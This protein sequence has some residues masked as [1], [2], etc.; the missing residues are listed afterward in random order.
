VRRAIDDPHVEI[1]NVPPGPREPSPI[2]SVDTESFRLLERTMRQVVP[3]AL[4]VPWLVVGGTDS[5]NFTSISA[6]VYRIGAMRLG[7]DD[8]KRAHGTDERVS[9]EAYADM[10]RFFVQLLTNGVT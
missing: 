4:V 5:R 3:A 9:I 8:T 10:V 2:S 7:P 1:R 6:E